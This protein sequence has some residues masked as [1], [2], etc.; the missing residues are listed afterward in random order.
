[1]VVALSMEKTFLCWLLKTSKRNR[2]FEAVKVCT[3]SNDPKYPRNNGYAQNYRISRRKQRFNT[4]IVMRT[5]EQ[6]LYWPVL[7]IFLRNSLIWLPRSGDKDSDGVM[8]IVAEAL[9]LSFT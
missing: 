1:M 3:V 6:K 5:I 7:V 8:A 9:E 4:E 2:Q